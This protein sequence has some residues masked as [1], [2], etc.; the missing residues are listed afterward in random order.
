MGGKARVGL[1]KLGTDNTYEFTAIVSRYGS[2]T[3]YGNTKIRT[4]M[5]KDIQLEENRKLVA[6][7]LWKDV[8]R[9]SKGLKPGDIIYF[10]ARVS[11][12]SK[13]RVLRRRDYTLTDIGG[14]A[15]IG[16]DK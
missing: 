12:Y 15:V 10:Y 7:H 4:I 9:W 2:R 6:R 14:V 5:L 13:G 11:S 3:I 1:Y 16:S 8:D